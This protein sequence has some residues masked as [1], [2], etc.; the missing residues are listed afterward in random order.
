M[1]GAELVCRVDSPIDRRVE[2]ASK[3][4]DIIMNP[5]YRPGL[6]RDHRAQGVTTHH[7][8]SKVSGDVDLDV[9]AQGN[10]HLY[11]NKKHSRCGR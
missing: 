4:G 9:E 11:H 3:Q 5:T 2:R 1:V 10:A 7:P 6:I 8:R